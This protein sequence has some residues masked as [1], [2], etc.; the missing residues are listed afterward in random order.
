[1]ALTFSSMT[2]LSSD[3]REELSTGERGLRIRSYGGG[4]DGGS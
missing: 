3:P 2:L 1:V 4:P